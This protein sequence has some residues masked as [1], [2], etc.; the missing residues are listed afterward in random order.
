MAI[1]SIYTRFLVGGTG[2]AFDFSSQS[3]SLNVST[4]SDKLE[5]TR[6]QDTAR[7]FVQGDTEGAI[8]VSGY[9]DNGGATYIEQEFAEMVANSESVYAAAI[10]GTN[11]TACPS[12]VAAG[13][14]VDNLKLASQVGNLITLN[15]SLT[16]GT[17]LQRGLMV[18]RG[19]ISA[20]G[21]T[22][23]ID[24]GAAGSSGGKAW[25]WVTA[26]TGTATNAAIVLQSDDNT[27]FTTP[28]TEC[29]FTF[30]AKGGY[31]QTLSGVIDRYLR[32][33]TTGMGGATNFSVVVVASVTG[34]TQ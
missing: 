2:E 31:Q 32:L 3:N 4:T 5:D 33:S 10:F 19:T 18:Y 9:F 24:L 28:A 29:T 30:S 25:L 20:T 16:A 27:G 8:E 17:G 6:F 34:I 15:G 12:Y 14:N 11:A 21:T 26:I 22:T 13:A 1:K 7:S 23:Y